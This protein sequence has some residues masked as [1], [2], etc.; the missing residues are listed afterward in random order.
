MLCNVRFALLC[1]V[2]SVRCIFLRCIFLTDTLLIMDMSKTR[3]GW[4]N[5]TRCGAEWIWVI[6]TELHANSLCNCPVRNL[7]GK[8]DFSILVHLWKTTTI[9]YCGNIAQA[10]PFWQ[11][12]KVQL[13]HQQ[14]IHRRDSIKALS[15][16]N[17]RS[18]LINHHKQDSLLVLP[19]T[20]LSLR[21]DHHLACFL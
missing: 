4:L 10:L 6:L 11:Q 1:I 2:S 9:I 21:V 7:E 14:I 3:L 15:L 12:C 5:I 16:I 17:M 20:H 18:N 8:P 19:E 13:W